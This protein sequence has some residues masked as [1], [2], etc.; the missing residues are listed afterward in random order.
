MAHGLSLTQSTIISFTTGGNLPTTNPQINT[1]QYWF[2]KGVDANT[3]AI[4][5]SKENA[6]ADTNRITISASGISS[7]VIKW[8]LVK[9]IYLEELSFNVRADS[10]KVYHFPAPTTI[11]TGLD[12]LNGSV[13]KVVADGYILTDKVVFNGSITIEI[14]AVDVIV[15]SQFIVTMVPLPVAI[16]GVMGVL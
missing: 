5:T 3:F 2:A 14:E 16:P 7:N 4:Y 12:H 13:V 15:G 10:A 9:K 1:T 8:P 11:V 6:D